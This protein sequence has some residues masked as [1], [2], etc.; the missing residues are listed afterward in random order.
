[1]SFPEAAEAGFKGMD[2]VYTRQILP[3]YFSALRTAKETGS[4]EQA[5][6]L[7][8]SIK[9]FQR[10]FG[11]EVIPSERKIETEILYNKYDI[12]RNLFSMYMLAGV[13]MLV[14]VIFQIFK[15]NKLLRGLITASKVAIL[16]FFLL[17]T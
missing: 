15:D 7:L 3:M 1:V 10:K 17:H 2:S 4:Y 11:E 16:I 5:D 8:N 14:L 12:F 6:E 13:L 9:G